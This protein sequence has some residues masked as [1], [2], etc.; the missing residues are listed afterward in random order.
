MRERHWRS[1]SDESEM[2]NTVSRLGRGGRT[3]EGHLVSET[4]ELRPRVNRRCPETLLWEASDE[5][6]AQADLLS[7]LAGG[8]ARGDL[9]RGSSSVDFFP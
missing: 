1:A 7:R 6:G 4:L 5:A 8:P 2:G 9:A 3:V